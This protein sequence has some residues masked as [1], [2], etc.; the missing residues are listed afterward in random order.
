MFRA[1]LSVFAFVL[2]M[3]LLPDAARAEP[4]PKCMEP[5][6][7]SSFDA[8]MTPQPCE[9]VTTARINW[10]GGHKNLRVI[11]PTAMPAGDNTALISRINETARVVGEAMDKMGGGLTT[12]DITIMMTA[13]VSPRE[14]DGEDVFRKGDV[15][16]EATDMFAHEC[17]VSYY[18]VRTPGTGNNFVFILSHEI[19]HCIQFRS[20]RDLPWENGWLIE[21]TAEY[22]AYLAKA[23]APSG[24]IPEF[25]A[26]IQSTAIARMDYPDVVFYLWL[27]HAYRPPQVKEFIDSARSIDHI[28]PDML[29][30]FAKAYFD[31]TIQLPFGQRLPST[32]R[33][34]RSLTV[35]GATTIASPAITPYTLTTQTIRFERSKIYHLTAGTVPDDAR[36]AWREGAGGISGDMPS[37]ITTC[38]GPKE[39]RVI[40]T[41]TR[42][43]T[44]GN[45]T[46]TAEPASASA[47]QCPAGVWQETVESARHYFE[48]SA[49][50][51]PSDTRYI[52]GTRTL[53]LNADKTG[54]FIYNSIATEVGQR[55][56]ELWLEQTKTGGTTFTWR[57]VNGLLY[58]VLI[59]GESNMITLHN[60]Q[61]SHS[62]TRSET[63]KAGPQ[64]IG[65]NFFCDA[66]GLHLR[67]AAMTTGT[68][69][70]G[71]RTGYTTD[72]DFVRVGSA[73]GS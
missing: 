46:V 12:D 72:M 43:S 54:S 47:C 15:E 59:G 60:T 35:S 29:F 2:S 36:T 18:K 49:F 24:F 30:N 20:W 48:Q 44:A 27:G 22:F 14:V 13:Y 25:D 51:G 31:Q 41:T 37:T 9:V 7:L 39:F 55:G 64:T 19:F 61:H 62:G 21:A 73:P 38:D 56:S 57:V 50:G 16:A 58:T 5:N 42:S 11:R 28:T 67:Q 8:R 3:I 1:A 45:I 66:A 26:Q 40:R 52:S 6:Y 32:P 33:A 53:T 23:E 69:M 34:G 10:R 65:H 68:F 70:D 71:Y 63:R 17:P 4:W